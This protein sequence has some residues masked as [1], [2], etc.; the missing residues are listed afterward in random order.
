MIQ[1]VL[2]VLIVRKGLLNECIWLYYNTFVH[3]KM[4]QEILMRVVKWISFPDTGL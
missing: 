4:R 2:V 1:A 3:A